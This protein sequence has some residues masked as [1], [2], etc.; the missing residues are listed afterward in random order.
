MLQLQVHLAVW[1]RPLPARLAWLA[2]LDAPQRWPILP[3]F[4]PSVLRQIITQPKS[5]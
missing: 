5:G 2:G 4:V 1:Q 3:L